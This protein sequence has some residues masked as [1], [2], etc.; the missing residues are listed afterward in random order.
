MKICRILSVALA[1]ILALAC[2]ASCGTESTEKLGCTISVDCSAVS[3]GMDEAIAPDDG[4]YILAPTEFTFAGGDTLDKVLT[5]A[6]MEKKLHYEAT[7][8]YFTAIGNLYTG[9][10]GEM[11]GWLYYVNGAI[12]EIGTKDYTV[13]HGDVIEFV[14]FEDF[15]KAFE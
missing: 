11:S 3:A 4:K 9:D 14:Y 13:C 8:G 12:P 15:N 10:F 1:T 6:F 7:D 5:S 2:L